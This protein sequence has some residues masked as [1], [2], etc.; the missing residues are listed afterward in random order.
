MN[1]IIEAVI[2]SYSGYHNLLFDDSYII[3]KN[4]TKPIPNRPKDWKENS[5][6]TLSSN[7]TL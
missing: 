1:M 3:V 6:I 7:L 5:I 2:K 4:L